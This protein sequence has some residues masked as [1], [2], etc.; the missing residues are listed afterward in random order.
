[1]IINNIFLYHIKLNYNTFFNLEVSLSHNQQ[2]FLTARALEEKSINLLVIWN[3]TLII[4]IKISL[5]AIISKIWTTQI[6]KCPHQESHK[7]RNCQKDPAKNFPRFF[8]HQPTPDNH[9]LTCTYHQWNACERHLTV[10]LIPSVHPWLSLLLWRL[11]LRW[12]NN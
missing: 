2:C 7:S 4:S 11:R 1:M 5:K 10:Q 6:K 8:L 12:K 3:L 9:L